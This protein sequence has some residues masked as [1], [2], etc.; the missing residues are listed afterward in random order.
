MLPTLALMAALQ[1]APQQDSSLKLTNASL[2]YSAL[3]IRARTTRFCRE[4]C[5]FVCFDIEGLKES[6]DGKVAYS[7]GMEM[8][9][10]DGKTLFKQEPQKAEALNSLGGGKVPGFAR[11]DI[12]DTPAGEY[13]MT[14]TIIDNN[15]KDKVTQSLTQKFEVLPKGLGI[16]SLSMSYDPKNELPA[17]PRA[18]R[19]NTSSSTSAW[20]ALD[21]ISSRSRTSCAR[22]TSSTTR[23][24]P[25]WRSRIRAKSRMCPTTPCCTRRSSCLRQSQ[26]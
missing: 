10:K 8:K 3:R 11:P 12:G 20:S 2:S 18:C 6:A 24:R 1:V 17:R 25:F 5:S 4:T 22:C 23:A 19:G 14:V 16:V 15:S 7:I 9:N 21:A 13:T 26:W